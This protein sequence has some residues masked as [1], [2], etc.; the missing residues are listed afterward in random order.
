MT[1]LALPMA[2][3]RGAVWTGRVLSAVAVLFM[4]F[5][6]TIHILKPTP[7]VQA[8]AQLGVPEHLSLAIGLLERWPRSSPAPTFADR[9][10]RRP[11]DGVRALRDRR[12]HLG[13]AD[14]ADLSGGHTSG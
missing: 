10:L 6:G 1:T 7:V 3:S 14:G 2:P 12:L 8:F 13:R 5:D 11:A 9:E 4:V